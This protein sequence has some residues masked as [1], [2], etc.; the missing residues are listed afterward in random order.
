MA[1]LFGEESA[2]ICRLCA[3]EITS[4]ICRR[5][6]EGH[7]APGARD[8]LLAWLEDDVTHCR[9]VEIVP[10]VTSEAALLLRRYPLSAADSLQLASCLLLRRELTAPPRFVTYDRRLASAAVTEGLEV[11]PSTPTR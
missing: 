3:V 5:T 2:A 8:R 4:V 9:V 7:F 6:R 10:A 11:L 1:A